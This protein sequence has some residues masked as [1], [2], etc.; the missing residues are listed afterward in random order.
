MRF[1][2]GPAKG[3]EGIR[4]HQIYLLRGKLFDQKREF[5]EASVSFANSLKELA[6]SD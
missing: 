5:K 3:M 6:S 4:L 1:I 2:Q